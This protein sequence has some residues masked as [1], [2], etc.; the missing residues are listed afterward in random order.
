MLSSITSGSTRATEA[1][2]FPVRASAAAASS[3]PAAMAT[4]CCNPL[5]SER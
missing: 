2:V 4:S 3:V 5:N 1:R